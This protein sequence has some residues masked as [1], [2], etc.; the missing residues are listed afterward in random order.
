[1]I[2]PAFGIEL[3]G[4]LKPLLGEV[5]LALLAEGDGEFEGRFGLG[6]GG[7]PLL[8]AALVLVV[9]K[10]ELA[11]GAFGDPIAQGGDVGVALGTDDLAAYFQFL[12]FG[13][14]GFGGADDAALFV[15]P[16]PGRDVG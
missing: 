14:R 15:D 12:V 8:D 5:G 11:L 1:M 16:D 10:D 9:G 3:F 7:A 6:L 13:G 2:V 4:A